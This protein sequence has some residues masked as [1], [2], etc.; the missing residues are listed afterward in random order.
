MCFNPCFSGMA[1]GTPI[2]SEVKVSFISVSILVFLEWPLGRSERY[3]SR[4]GFT[5]FNPCFSGMAF[6]TISAV[7]PL[8]PA[9]RFQSLFFW[10]G[11]WDQIRQAGRGH[12]RGVSILVFLEWPLGRDSPGALIAGLQGFNP[13]FSGMAFGTEGIYNAIAGHPEF[14][15]LFFWNG[16]WDVVQGFCREGHSGVSILVFLEWP[17]GRAM[18]YSAV[19]HH[20]RFQSLF[21]WNGLW[22]RSA[23][24]ASPQAT[25]C[26][27]PCFS[28]MAFGTI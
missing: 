1:F 14:Q 13:C 11:L 7:S 15:S 16:L 18:I 28:G 3:Q 26:F 24:L 8:P 10:N 19:H 22:D 4:W 2:S 6:G 5:S 23:S 21:F 9:Q 17:L 20:R 25:L 27:N 12:K